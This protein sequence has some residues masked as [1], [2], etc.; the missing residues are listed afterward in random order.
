VQEDCILFA[1]RIVNNRLPMI[2]FILFLFLLLFSSSS[3]AQKAEPVTIPPGTIQVNDT[4]FADITEVANMH[5]REY[6]YFLQDTESPELNKAFP[7]T[8]VWDDSLISLNGMVRYYFR[9]PSFNEYPVVGVSY[10][11]AIAFCKW[12]TF[13]AN[14]GLYVREKKI[15]DW[16]AHLED[17]IPIHF[18]YRLPTKK[19]WEQIA[20]GNKV[21]D[22]YPF[23]YDSTYLKSKKK[24]VPVFNCVYDNSSNPGGSFYS[25]PI[26]SFF[27]N[28]TGIYNMIGNVA[29]MVSEMGLAKGG[30]FAHSLDDCKIKLDQSYSR[31]EKWLGFRC[32]AVR[33]K[34]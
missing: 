16:R 11:Q 13:M 12:R 22:N 9:H 2:G 7:D 32:V 10:E 25:A 24:Y 5:W 15:R 1:A 29:E 17:S 19:E 3:P 6:L 34:K 20:A 8:L 28:S 14:F 23:G 21:P 27:P 31:P 33:L 4:L 18:Y 26:Q 30:S